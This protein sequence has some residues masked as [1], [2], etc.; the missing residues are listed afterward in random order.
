MVR[1]ND[2]SSF[3]LNV[4]KHG[5]VILTRAFLL[6][7]GSTRKLDATEQASLNMVVFS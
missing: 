1:K 6:V 5:G 4:C 7:F 3:I 2:F